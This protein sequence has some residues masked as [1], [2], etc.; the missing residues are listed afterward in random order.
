MCAVYW[1]SGSPSHVIPLVDI[2]EHRVSGSLSPIIDDICIGWVFRLLLRMPQ[3]TSYTCS[4]RLLGCTSHLINEL[5]K[6][7]RAGWVVHLLLWIPQHISYPCGWD[8]WEVPLISLISW[9][10][11]IGTISL[12]MDAS[13]TI[14]LAMSSMHDVQHLDR[15]GSS[16]IRVL[17]LV[18]WTDLSV[19]SGKILWLT[20]NQFL[21]LS[22]SIF[23]RVETRCK[24]STWWQDG[25]M[26]DGHILASGILPSWERVLNCENRAKFHYG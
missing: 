5:G 3:N 18:M 4:P 23:N 9:E 21:L 6:E 8:S 15:S 22:I 10:N 7:D 13:C 1:V 14:I 19:E 24:D 20:L 26:I 11:R 12:R 17:A 2:W 16:L 25:M